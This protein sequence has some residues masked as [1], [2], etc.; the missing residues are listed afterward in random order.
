M[1]NFHAS[2]VVYDHPACYSAL[3]K[4]EGIAARTGL[5]TDELSLRWLMHHS[6]LQDNDVVILGASK[7]VHI[8]ESLEKLFKGPLEEDVADALSAL[9]TLELAEVSLAMVDPTQWK[10]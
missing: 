10:L 9:W 3:E 6:Q 5:S 7:I 4:L 1:T 8:E 2:F